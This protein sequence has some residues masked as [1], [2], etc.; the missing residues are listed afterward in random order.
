MIGLSLAPARDGAE[1]GEVSLV[2]NSNE[3]TQVSGRQIETKIWGGRLCRL[4]GR[5]R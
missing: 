4:R 5:D 3:P 2:A 1:R